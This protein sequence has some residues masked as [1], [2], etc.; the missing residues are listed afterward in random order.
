MRAAPALQGFQRST[1]GAAGEN[2]VIHQHH[3]TLLNAV[4]KCGDLGHSR[5]DTFQIIPMKRWI[6]G[7]LRDGVSTEP[8]Q[9]L[10]QHP[11]QLDATGGD[12]QEH[13]VMAVINGF[14]HLR[15]QA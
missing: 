7:S 14:Q 10:C 12:S 6:D 4:W 2:H 8:L 3:L 11:R 1:H 15:S 9:L 5:T 13:Q